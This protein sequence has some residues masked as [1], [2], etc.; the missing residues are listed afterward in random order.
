MRKADAC[1]EV[2][3]VHVRGILCI[4]VWVH[5]FEPPGDLFIAVLE[6]LA[7]V[8]FLQLNSYGVLGENFEG[9]KNSG[10]EAAADS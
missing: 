9:Y 5:Q 1:Y 6:A 8:G 3:Y 4:A 10:V 2:F 7:L